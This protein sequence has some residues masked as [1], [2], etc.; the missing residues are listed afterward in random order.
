MTDQRPGGLIVDY[1]GVLDD[2]PLVLD[3]ARRARA[4]GVRTAVF[5]GGHAV[6]DECVATFELVLLGAVSGARKPAPEA[7]VNA[8]RAL[9]LPPRRCVVVDD[10]PVNVRGAAAAGAVGVLHRRP[11]ATL[12]ELEILLGVPAAEI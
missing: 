12:A 11:E 10:V 4:A 2:G 3:Y 9:G 6:P 1:G 5:S 7:F 8:A